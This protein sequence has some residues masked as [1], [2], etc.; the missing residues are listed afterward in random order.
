MITF[1]DAAPHGILFALYL[2]AAAISGIFIGATG[3]GGVLLVPLLLLLDVPVHIASVAVLSNFLLVGIVS[4]VTNWH[5]TLPRKRAAVVCT[6][7]APGVILGTLILPLVHP[8]AISLLIATI[9]IYSGVKLLV[10]VRKELRSA[11]SSTSSSSDEKQMLPMTP[12]E[13]FDS[14]AISPADSEAELPAAAATQDQQQQWRWLV[15]HTA[16]GGT[17]G[18]LSVLTATGGPFITLPLL[19]QFWPSTPPVEGVALGLATAIPISSCVAVVASFSSSSTLDAGLA[20]SIAI[21][22]ALGAPLGTRL[23]RQAKPEHLKLMIAFFL[24]V[25]GAS[26]VV[27]TCAT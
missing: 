15:G 21:A 27:K 25:I 22:V 23:A 3:I 9:S 5:T 10:A 4:V 26:A 13:N 17:I 12:A 1:F 11:S 18:F 2:L 8:K 14:G 7:V 6:A 20:A 24:L 19:H 16:L